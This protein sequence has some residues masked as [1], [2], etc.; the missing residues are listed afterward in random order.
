MSYDEWAMDEAESAKLL[1]LN[2]KL[3]LLDAIDH[4]KGKRYAHDANREPMKAV[5]EI[6]RELKRVQVANIQLEELGKRERK[7]G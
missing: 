3:T 6:E 4:N 7:D 1:L 2:S 5:L